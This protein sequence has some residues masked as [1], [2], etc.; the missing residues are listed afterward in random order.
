MSKP[1]PQK[2]LEALK[3]NKLINPDATIDD[4]MNASAEFA[5]AGADRITVV[6]S[7]DGYFAVTPLA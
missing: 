7:D 3:E 2:I 6:Y 4:L 5:T 1:D